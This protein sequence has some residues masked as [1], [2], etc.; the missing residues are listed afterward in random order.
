MDEDT[1]A[2]NAAAWAQL[3]LTVLDEGRR[4]ATYK[5][6][7]LLALIDCCALSAAAERALPDA[8]ARTVGVVELNLVQMPLGK[9]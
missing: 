1:N 5:L 4:T 7:V 2:G 9:L 3:V 8:Y 6:A